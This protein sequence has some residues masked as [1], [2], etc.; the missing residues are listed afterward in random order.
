MISQAM[1]VLFENGQPLYL[2]THM[3]DD[4]FQISVVLL[5]VF[6]AAIYLSSVILEYPIVSSRF[7]SPKAMVQ[8]GYG[9]VSVSWVLLSFM[10]R[11]RDGYL[12]TG[13]LTWLGHNMNFHDRFSQNYTDPDQSSLMPPLFLFWALAFL[14]LSAASGVIIENSKVLLARLDQEYLLSTVADETMESSEVALEIEEQVPP[15]S[16]STAVTIENDNATPVTM[17]NSEVAL[18]IKEQVPP[19]S[20]ATAVTIENDNATP[21]TMEQENSLRAST[22]TTAA[23]ATTTDTTD[24]TNTTTTTAAATTTVTATT[25]AT[26]ESS[27]V[28]LET[29]DQVGDVEEKSEQQPKASKSKLLPHHKEPGYGHSKSCAP[30]KTEKMLTAKEEK[31]DEGK[32]D[33]SRLFTLSSRNVTLSTI[34]L[35]IGLAQVGVH[36]LTRQYSPSMTRLFWSE[37]PE[38][39]FGIFEL[40]LDFLTYGLVMGTVMIWVGSRLIPAN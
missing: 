40:T 1:A 38:L 6:A 22:T 19:L 18:E 8:L 16:P 25:D 9:A 17:E 34:A 21:V 4:T 14:L 10:Q 31:E 36:I 2:L 37:P 29:I 30:E 15:P 20:P 26:I 33:D 7:F 27:N 3:M 5:L 23:T 13:H 32:D 11:V 28:V 24:T 39:S 35:F 12:L